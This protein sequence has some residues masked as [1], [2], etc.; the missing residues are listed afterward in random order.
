MKNDNLFFSLFKSQ[1]KHQVARSLKINHIRFVSN[2]FFVQPINEVL[3]KKAYFISVGGKNWQAMVNDGNFDP[4][5]QLFVA[6]FN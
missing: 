4:G 5:L 3:T 6:M 2:L 1:R